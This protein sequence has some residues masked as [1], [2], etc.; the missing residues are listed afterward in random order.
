MQRLS[1]LLLLTLGAI[2]CSATPALA[3]VS[4]SDAAATHAYLQARIA[5]E[6]TINMDKPTELKAI[7]E[8]ATAVKTECPDVLAG[9]PPHT[10]GEKT[11]ASTRE[12]EEELLSATFGAGER[13][14][15]PVLARFA[16]TVGRL[17]WS[18]PSLTR[19]LRDLA[20]E[21]AAQSAIPFPDLCSDLK[22]WVASGYT[23]VSPGTKQFFHR[24]QVVSGITTIEPEPHEPIG[25]L[26]N[27][28]ALVAHRLK[29]YE[30]HADRVLARKA[31][32]PEVQLT[33]PA[34]RPLFEAA[35]SV[36]VALG[37]ASA[38]AA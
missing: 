7:G 23:A 38:P 28:T 26:F 9:A 18:S 12:I 33:D 31:L 15:H 20:I 1:W 4:A 36:L 21:E 6:R 24:R 22:F 29:P 3:R 34:L 13:V 27:L 10:K 11:N 2:V 30:D 16:R 5:L 8:L 19:L 14:E 35:E 37:R 32:P 25:N 17:R